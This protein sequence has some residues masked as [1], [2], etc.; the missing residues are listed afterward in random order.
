MEINMQGLSGGKKFNEKVQWPNWQVK[1]NQHQDYDGMKAA[2]T[3]S[4][5]RSNIGKG[6]KANT[7]TECIAL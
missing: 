6:L 4:L 1:L 7:H 2:G 3:G 5:I